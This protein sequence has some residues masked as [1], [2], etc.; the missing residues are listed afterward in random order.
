MELKAN[1]WGLSTSIDLFVCNHTKMND[2]EFIKSTVIEL[3]DLIEMKRYGDCN[4]I[5]FGSGNKKGYSMFQLIETSNISAHFA[6]ENL[7]IYFDI[8]SCKG[9]DPEVVRSFLKSKFESRMERVVSVDRL[10]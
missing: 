3:C 6:N 7:T 2:P 1:S 10:I 4:L 9:Y 8:F 5:F